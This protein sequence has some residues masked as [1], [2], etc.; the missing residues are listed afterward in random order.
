LLLW[1]LD[2]EQGSWAVA[3]YDEGPGPRQI[4]QY[5]PRRLWDDVEAAFRAWAD[6]GKPSLDQSHITVTAQTQAV[7]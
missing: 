5:G 6:A 3:R 2:P 1:L 7:T 4:R